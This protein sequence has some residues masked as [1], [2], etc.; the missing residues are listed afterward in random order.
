[1]ARVFFIGIIWLSAFSVR[2][3]NN[4]PPPGDQWDLQRCVDYAFK[5]NISVR[6][7]DL[8]TRFAAL[9]LQQSRMSQ[10][11]FISFG[12]NGGYSAG[13]NQDPTNFSLITTAY[14]FSSATLQG[15]VDLFNWFT[16]KNTIAAKNLS[17]QAA[18]AGFEKAKNDVA[19]NVAVA[20]LQI[21]LAKEQ[22]ELAKT[23]VRYSE[24]Q[25]ESTRKQVDAGKL[26]ELNAVNL[27]SVLAADSASLINAQISVNQLTLQMKA[28]LNLDPA[29]PFDL[30]TPPVDKIPLENLADLQPEAVYA[31]AL[32]SMPQQKQDDLNQQAALK[33][34]KAAK[35]AMYP[36]FSLFGSLGTSY[37]NKAQEVKSK[38]AVN[39]PIGTVS[40]NGTPY[41]VFSLS[42]FY[43]YTYGKMRYFDQINQNFRQSVGISVNVPIL[44]GGSLRTAW[45]RSKLD[46]QRV[47][48]QK[49]QNRFSLKQDIYKAYNDATG[50]M[51]KYN[52][53]KKN[54]ES[55]QKA[56]DFGTRRYDLGLISTF[57]LITLQTN[58]MRAKSQ[59][60]YSQ[61]DYV[62]KMKLLEFYRG[63]GLKL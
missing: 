9:D 58:L 4:P 42:P 63:Q 32:K 33:S 11:P 6:Q 40:V 13:R 5:N 8:Q 14:T 43:D 36:T 55:A 44:N 17:F 34:I 7:A 47:E 39:P 28:L 12:A 38:V 15:N 20:Y 18:E 57:D 25:L 49:E 19:L 35:G 31:L 41:Q 22:V 46:L 56:Y 1:M 3:Q 29:T 23:Q 16:K 53:D 60:L 50:S 37:N 24:S 54:V 62:F 10:Y 59:L 52:A 2:A 26:P 27:E 48:L 45:Q 21:L 61:Y 30:V 51:Q